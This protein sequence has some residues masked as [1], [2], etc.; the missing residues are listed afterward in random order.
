MQYAYWQS[1]WICESAGKHVFRNTVCVCVCVHTHTHT[2][3]LWFGFFLMLENCSMGNYQYLCI[4]FNLLIQLHCVWYNTNNVA[5]LEKTETEYDSNT[6]HNHTWKLLTYILIRTHTMSRSQR[7][8]ETSSAGGQ[9][10]E[11]AIKQRMCAFVFIYIYTYIHTHI[12]IYIYIYHFTATW[13]L[14]KSIL[15]GQF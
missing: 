2:H 12:Y 3:T 11:A 5:D 15:I 9:G 13:T 7:R 6:S 10:P 14:N 4:G 1:Y 8:M